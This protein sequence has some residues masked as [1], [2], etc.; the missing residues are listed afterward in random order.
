M[1]ATAESI[2]AGV[3]AGAGRTGAQ[4]SQLRPLPLVRH[5]HLHQVKRDQLAANLLSP[6]SV[7]SLVETVYLKDHTPIPLNLERQSPHIL[8]A[9]LG[10]HAAHLVP[11]DGP[12]LWKFFHG[13][14]FSRSLPH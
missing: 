9:W 6:R 13:S 11:R 2:S 3:A 14:S 8:G 10:P 4:R 12:K 1:G 5:H 7:Y